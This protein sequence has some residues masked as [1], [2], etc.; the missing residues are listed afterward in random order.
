MK[1]LRK[2]LV[3]QITYLFDKDIQLVNKKVC[4]S[5]CTMPCSRRMEKHLVFT[6]HWYLPC[7]LP[8]SNYLSFLYRYCTSTEASSAG[9]YLFIQYLRV[10]QKRITR[11]IFGPKWDGN[12]EWRRLH[13]EELHSLYRSS[14][15]VRVIKSRR[16]RWDGHVD[17]MKEGRSA[18][19]MLTGT[20]TGKRPLGNVV[21][22]SILILHY[23]MYHLVH[24][25]MQETC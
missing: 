1:A 12:G 9:V 21:V 8:S 20:P 19:K 22:L 5:T 4:L 13:N 18:S 16:L 25:T 24:F 11:R 7:F 17:R 6:Q 15:I 3:K 23:N 14:I 2:Q 10:F